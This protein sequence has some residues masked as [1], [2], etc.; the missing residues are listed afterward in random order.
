MK[1]PWNDV[2]VVVLVAA[3]EAIVEILKRLGKE[4]RRHE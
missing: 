3:S 2:L 1:K 4:R